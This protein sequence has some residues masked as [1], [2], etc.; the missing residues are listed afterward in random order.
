MDSPHEEEFLIGKPTCDRFVCGQHEL[1]DH[2][3]AFGVL[4]GMS[5]ADFSIVVQIDF[6]FGQN[7]VDRSSRHASF[8]QG[9]GQGVH[10]ADDPKHIRSEFL[11]PR[12]V[13]F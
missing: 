12:F 5:A 1:F 7:Q 2:L 6:D 3:M 10:V 4:H 13:V 11:F 9:H 8:S